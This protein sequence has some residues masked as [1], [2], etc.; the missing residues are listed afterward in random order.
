MCIWYG[1]AHSFQHTEEG[2]TT[3]PLVYTNYLTIKIIAQDY[4][5]LSLERDFCVMTVELVHFELQ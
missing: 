2:L 5:L 3:K 1:V 4:S